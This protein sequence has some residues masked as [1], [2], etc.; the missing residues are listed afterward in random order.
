MLR[1]STMLISAT[2]L[3]L[4]SVGLMYSLPSSAANQSKLITAEQVDW[5]YLNP[6]RGDKSPGAAN[7]W[8]DRVK[9]GATGMLVRFNKGFASPA[10]IHNISYRGVVIEG[11]MHN[12]NPSAEKMWMP[13][14]SF[15]TQPAG[16][17]HIT[18]ANGDN[19]LIYLEIDSGPYLVKPSEEQFDNGERP[20]NQHVNNMVWLGSEQL[21]VVGNSQAKVS[22]LWGNVSAGQS[23]G[24]LVSLPAG[25][26]GDIQ[27][28]AAEFRSVMISGEMTYQSKEIA[29]KTRI[30]QGSYF[31]STG[32][33]SHQIHTQKP[34]LLY[35]RTDGEMKLVD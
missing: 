6:L 25:F 35:I 15:W 11:L 12:A 21:S 13:T 27:V 31:E 29:D 28:N 33:F 18:A 3:S 17:N 10:H 2:V 7:L 19:N 32:K 1:Q 16:E 20:I 26:T 9:D 22:Y 4:S 23:H 34:S 24:M 8:G 5:G 30:S 14:G